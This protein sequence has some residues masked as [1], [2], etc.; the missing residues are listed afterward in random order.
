M[1]A[2]CHLYT[3][4][5]LMP[6]ETFTGPSEST[7]V[8]CSNYTPKCRC[9]QGELHTK[10]F[11][12][13]AAAAPFHHWSQIFFLSQGRHRTQPFLSKGHLG[14]FLLPPQRILNRVLQIL[15]LPSFTFAF[16]CLMCR[17]KEHILWDRV[18]FMVKNFSASGK[19]LL[20]ARSHWV[21]WFH[22][23][24]LPCCRMESSRKKRLYKHHLRTCFTLC[25]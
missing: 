25:H 3:L 17:E 23:Y 1:A 12:L 21:V 8:K 20:P 13:P 9:E 14:H 7:L 6:H 16:L 15:N 11:V 24:N 18:G 5:F 4:P 2:R 22:C 19:A 10:L